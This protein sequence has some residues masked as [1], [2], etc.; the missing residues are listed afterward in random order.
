MHFIISKIS[1]FVMIM[2]TIERAAIKAEAIA[3]K[4]SA[5]KAVA[6]ELQEALNNE[7]KNRNHVDMRGRLDSKGVRYGKLI[8]Y[9]VSEQRF[10]ELVD[11][12]CETSRVPEY[13]LSQKDEKLNETQD[14]WYKAPKGTV[15]G[16]Q[17]KTEQREIQAYCE[18]IL[19]EVEE[20]L[21]TMLYEEKLN[22]T[23]VEHLVC[24]ELSP[25]CVDKKSWLKEKKLKK[26]SGVDRHTGKFDT[27]TMKE[28]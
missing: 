5:C 16:A 6:N 14:S 23:N 19:E 28:L 1:F 18:R 11:G 21:Q 27:A 2:I 7:N 4:C 12:F 8:P 9:E 17:A 26:A 24:F 10:L 15:R 3:G 22:E 25:Q 13:Q 20:E